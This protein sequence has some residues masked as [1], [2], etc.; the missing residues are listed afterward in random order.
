MNDEE[1]S[2]LNDL[3]FNERLL[4]TK[5]LKKEPEEIETASNIKQR[6]HLE[7]FLVELTKEVQAKYVLIILDV[8]Q[9][10]YINKLL[11]IKSFK[12]V[13]HLDIRLS[14]YI[15]DNQ[16]KNISEALIV[17]KTRPCVVYV[18]GGLKNLVQEVI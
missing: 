5:S 18:L 6:N 13:S 15:F 4:K 7:E 11:L 16:K 2:Y 12:T 3:N 1:Q 8:S 9:M 17:S 10:N 14:V